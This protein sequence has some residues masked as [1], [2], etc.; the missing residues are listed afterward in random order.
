[1]DGTIRETL[2]EGLLGWQVTDC[3][4]T[5]TRSGYLAPGTGRRDFRYLTPL[6]LMAALRAAG[7]TVCEP[8]HRFHLEVPSDTVGAVA[9]AVA[10]LGAV[11]HTI[12]P[13]GPMSRLEGDVATSRMHDLQ[14]LLPGLTRGEGVFAS[15]FDHYR[16][17]R[18]QPPGRPRTDRDPLNRGEYLRQILP[19]F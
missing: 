19:R 1:M 17:V 10:R 15:A 3:R 7:T 13:R 8:V 11:T 12:E 14:R 9:Q 6:V 2:R 4:V 18:G 5:M 16:P